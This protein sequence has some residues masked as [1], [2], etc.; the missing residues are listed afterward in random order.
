MG[1]PTAGIRQDKN[2]PVRQGLGLQ[3]K[4]DSSGPVFWEQRAIDRDTKQGNGVRTIM[5]YCGDEPLPACYI[6][7]RLEHIDPCAGPLDDICQA[8]P[9]IR[10]T[11][12]VLMGEW[13]RRELRLEQEFPEPVRVAG[14]VVSSSG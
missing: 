4:A 10:K 11:P 14:E 9:P 5:F 1:I 2:R 13:L 8:E 6:F 3:P 7:S 12:I